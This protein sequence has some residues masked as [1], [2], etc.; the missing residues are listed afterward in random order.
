MKKS[1]IIVMV[2][3]AIDLFDDKIFLEYG[4]PM[5]TVN[6]DSCTIDLYFNI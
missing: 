3:F 5:E 4:K 6:V 1:M 2:P